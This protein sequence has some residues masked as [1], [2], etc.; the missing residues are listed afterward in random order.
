MEGSWLLDQKG[1]CGKNLNVG[2]E[3]PLKKISRVP[4]TMEHSTMYP[5]PPAPCW[6]QDLDD[7]TSQ[8]L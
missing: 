1:K 5:V 8:N 3:S 2:P 6:A 4:D 7:G